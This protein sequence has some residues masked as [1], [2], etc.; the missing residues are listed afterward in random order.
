MRTR[1]L[2]ILVFDFIFSM[3]PGG[4]GANRMD[5]IMYRA[6]KVCMALNYLFGKESL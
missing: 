6:P 2:S 3:I 4:E 5:Q 1:K